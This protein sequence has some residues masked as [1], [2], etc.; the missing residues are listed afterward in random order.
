MRLVAPAWKSRGQLVVCP[1]AARSRRRSL[2]PLPADATIERTGASS[3]GPPA[4]V[5]DD[6]QHDAAARYEGEENSARTT[7]RPG[8]SG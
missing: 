7:S 3:A 4:P 2:P 5:F 8:V 1:S 6:V